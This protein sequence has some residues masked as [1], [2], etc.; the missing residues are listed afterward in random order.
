VLYFLGFDLQMTIDAV[1]IQTDGPLLCAG[2][3]FSG[4]RWLVFRSR[5][6]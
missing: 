3:D 5:S 4:Q 1:L 6:A 2:R